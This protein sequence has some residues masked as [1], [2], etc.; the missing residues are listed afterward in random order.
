MI[1]SN[2][3][4]LGIVL[5]RLLE[6]VQRNYYSWTPYEG[7]QIKPLSRSAS[8]DTACVA[9]ALICCPIVFCVM[10]S[11]ESPPSSS[12]VEGPSPS[13][14]CHFDNVPLSSW[15]KSSLIT[16]GQF[17]NIVDCDASSKMK[18]VC[19][20]CKNNGTV[21]G[22]IGSSSNLRSHIKVSF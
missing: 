11:E 22:Y 8:Q 14:H 4:D 15:P 12:R 1:F 10:T 21:T 13:W 5:S 19:V 3:F 16:S 2:F 9:C 17:F 18:F 6:N 7:V 20:H